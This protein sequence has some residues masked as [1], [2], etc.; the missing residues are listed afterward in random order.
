MR[1]HPVKT[2]LRP[3]LLALALAASF[4]AHAQDSALGTDLWFGNRL[5][6]ASTAGGNGCDPQGAT[7]LPGER[8]RTPTGFLYACPPGD[9]G[10]RKTESGVDVLAWLGLGF[11]NGRGGVDNAIFNR[12]SGFAKDPMFSLDLRLQRAWTGEYFN[13]YGNRINNDSQYYRLVAGRAGQFR[14]QAFARSQ[15]N[16]TSS[17][18]KSLWSNLGEQNLVLMPGL[19]R[20]ATTPAQIDAFMATNPETSVRVRRDKVGAGLNTY[21]SPRWTAFANGS[22]EKREGSRPFG[23]PFSFGRLVELLRPI[24]DSTVN[25]NGGARF[26]GRVWHM[27]FVYSGSFFRN[28]MDHYTY[29]MPYPTTNNNPV[30]L[31][32]Y[33]PQNDYHR[34]GATLTRKLDFAWKGEFSITAS[35]ARSSQNEPLVPG[36][37]ACR[38]GMLNAT[39]SCDNWNMPASLSRPNADMAINNTRLGARLSLQP[40]STITWRTTLNGI[41]EDYSGTYFAYNPL[42][43]QYGYIAENGAFPNTVWRP[44]ASNMVHVRNLPLDK[45]TVEFTT[46]VDWR[47][48]PANTLGGSYGFTR[49]ERTH[50]EFESTDDHAFRFNWTNR[51]FEW[52]TFRANYSYLDRS[53]GFYNFD[54][55][56]FLYTEELPGFVH[57]AAGIAPHTVAQM[58]KYDVGEREQHKIDLMGTFVLPNQM[59]LYASLRNERNKYD[60][61]IGRRGYDTQAMSL[62]WEWQPAVT[63]SVNAWIGW[64][65]S[66][67]DMS[68]TNDVPAGRNPNL[69]G[70]PPALGGNSAYPDGYR[71]W[72]FDKQRNFNGG[73]GLKFAV[74]KATVDVDW[75]YIDARGTTNWLAESV[76]A[77]NGTSAGLDGAFPDMTYRVNSFNVAVNVPLGEGFSMR[78]FGTYETGKAYDWHYAGFDSDRTYGNLIYTDGGPK[79]YHASLIGVLF[80]IQL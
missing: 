44:G 66:D 22:I 65:R 29:E 20:G 28:G 14:V 77:G 16:V 75:H 33:E 41:R 51:S 37:F 36:L 21:L 1:N 35:G 74:R 63:T 17:T 13:L 32:S 5:E 73:L 70:L 64:D 55:Y 3:S 39:V 9:D 60:T 54:P 7:W 49:I 43:G 23:G 6:P 48:N 58:R 78:A 68:N 61:L 59:T 31:F 38:G 56:E 24:D 2:I 18:A 45:Q 12:Y 34:L 10:W 47:L 76:N 53:G 50:R 42:T 69:G 4:G 25:V 11:L 26:V 46:G 52:M 8:H 62:Q 67:L 57:P 80:K 40:S 19:A 30:G 72:M 15:T 79:G 71:W 27:E